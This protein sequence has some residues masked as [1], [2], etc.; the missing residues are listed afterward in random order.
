MFFDLPE[1]V[2][3][4]GGEAV[5][6]TFQF[7][8]EPPAAIGELLSAQ[9]NMKKG[10]KVN[11]MPKRLIRVAVVLLIFFIIATILGVLVSKPYLLDETPLSP[12]FF[13]TYFDKSGAFYVI[14]SGLIAPIVALIVFLKGKQT[15]TYVGTNGTYQ[16][17][18]GKPSGKLFT[19]DTAEAIFTA[20]TEQFYNG[21]YNGTNYNYSWVNNNRKR[22]HTIAGQYRQKQGT[23]K[24]L[25]D[26]FYFCD[27]ASYSWNNYKYTQLLSQLKS[28]E[29]ISF[30]TG[31]TVV[32]MGLETFSIVHKKKQLDWDVSDIEDVQVQQGFVN[33]YNSKH[34]NMGFFAK[35][36][37]QG[38]VSFAYASMPNAQIFLMLMDILLGKVAPEQ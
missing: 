34:T 17:N 5:N 14:L 32:N 4:H 16:I 36:F 2:P 29:V 10:G 23:P 38:K 35:M 18:Y 21:V 1:T 26:P 24:K 37:G 13:K 8:G 30:N 33:I 11:T 3:N 22:V 15:C 6:S 31:A 9:S 7:F 27:A 25:N 19:F 28:G 12:S 20:R